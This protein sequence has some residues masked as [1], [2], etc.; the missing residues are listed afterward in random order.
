MGIKVLNTDPNDVYYT[1]AVG[2]N[3]RT[4]KSKVIF[5]P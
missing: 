3:I 5:L 4:Y 2:A 1:T